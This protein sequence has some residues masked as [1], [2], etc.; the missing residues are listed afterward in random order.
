MDGGGR[1]CA[2]ATTM[3]WS[4]AIAEPTELSV[5]TLTMT[6]HKRKENPM[7]PN[8]PEPHVPSENW[9][10]LL[11]DLKKFGEKLATPEVTKGAALPRPKIV[12]LCG[13]TRFWKTFQEQSLRLTM[14]GVI[15]LSIGCATGSDDDHGITEEQKAKFDELH[16]RKID[17]CDEILVL[18]VGGYI[19]KSTQSEIDYAAHL[20][21][22][23]V[24]LSSEPNNGF[25]PQQ[26][27]PP[28]ETEP[29][30]G[31]V[32]KPRGTVAKTDLYW[33]DLFQ[34]WCP[35]LYI[36]GAEIGLL[37]SKVSTPA[38]PQQ[39]SGKGGD[40]TCADTQ[41]DAFENIVKQ[42]QDSVR[43]KAPE[44]TKGAALPVRI[45][46]TTGKPLKTPGECTTMD[47]LRS[48]HIHALAKLVHIIVGDGGRCMCGMYDDVAMDCPHILAMHSREIASGLI[49]SGLNERTVVGYFEK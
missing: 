41:S 7:T 8:Q 33:S 15:V 39:L 25:P 10:K 40:E 5:A 11:G 19:G 29:P 45:D 17:L 34:K 35:C 43:S 22:K 49:A 27:P 31:Y 23:V 24:Y 48:L 18:N 20:G 2:M 28:A 6:T 36:A 26:Q 38:A 12:C 32:L 21:R 42:T 16:K 3:W 14:D 1:L 4:A 44:V 30:V 13:S 37:T 9:N 47:D 46:A